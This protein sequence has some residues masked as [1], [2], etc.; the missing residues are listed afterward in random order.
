MASTALAQMSL[1]SAF[2]QNLDVQN[3][4]GEESYWRVVQAKSASC[5]GTAFHVGAIL[6]GASEEIAATLRDFGLLFGEVI[7]IY[8]D[9]ND[10]LQ[11]PVNPDWTQGRSNL[12]ILY[13]STA[14]HPLQAQFKRLLP[15]IGEVQTLQAAQRILINCGAVSYCV[16]HVVERYQRAQNLLDNTPIADPAP[17]LDLLARQKKPVVTLLQRIGAEVP[18]ELGVD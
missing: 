9:L 4:S 1:A 13:A 12:A 11:V 10:A 14:N 3:L 5:F 17:L 8:D 15:Q 2:G 18:P 6:G 7:Q 16:Y